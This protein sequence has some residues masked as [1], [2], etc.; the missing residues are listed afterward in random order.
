MIKIVREV[1][2][3]QFPHFS[4]LKITDVEV[5]GRDNRTYRLGDEMLVRMPSGPD[6][7]LQVEKEQ[8]LLPQLA[9]RLSIPIPTPIAIGHPSEIY[10]YH[11][12]IYRWLPGK[13]INLVNLTDVEKEELAYDLA[14]FLK[15]LQ[16]IKDI[17]HIP[18]GNGKRGDHVSVYDSGARQQ[19]AQ[20]GHIID[21][22]KSLALWERA[23]S[24]K[25]T[26]DPVWLHGDLAI[27]NI[28]VDNGRLSAVIDFGCTATGDSACDL[29]IAW[30][31]FSGKSRE[32]FISEM[33]LDHDSWLRGRGW[34][35]WKATFELC[36]IKNK[37]SDEAQVQKR[38][39]SQVVG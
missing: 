31:Y 38:I 34:A 17:P 30:T 11:F 22:E 39:I 27:G 25:W 12:S 14:K 2:D 28:L 5:Q 10:P 6:Y 8:G 13:S 32:I 9:E 35:L 15:E 3:K 36:Q 33:D 19:I 37:D 4:H 24:T 23:C 18:P 20:L 26:N 29:V 7:A 16:R 21:G 1:I